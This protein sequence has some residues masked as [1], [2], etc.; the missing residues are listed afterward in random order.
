MATGRPDPKKEA[1]SL[2]YN[3]GLRIYAT[4]NPFIQQEMEKIML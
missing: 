2:I 3:G 4:V 1:H